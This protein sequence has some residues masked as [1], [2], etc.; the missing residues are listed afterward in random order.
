MSVDAVSILCRVRAAFHSLNECR[1]FLGE[2]RTISSLCCVGVEIGCQIWDKVLALI[3]S[4]AN[5]HCLS[6]SK[7]E[8]E[9]SLIVSVS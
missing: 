8:N 7:H 6:L 5:M 9:S 4:F 1:D 3:S 2:A